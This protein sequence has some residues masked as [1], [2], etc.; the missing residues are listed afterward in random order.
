VLR[1]RR[2]TLQLR[3][4]QKLPVSECDGL[5]WRLEVCQLGRRAPHGGCQCRCSCSHTEL[6]ILHTQAQVWPVLQSLIVHIS[7]YVVLV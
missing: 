4:Y 6:C 5:H 2:A 7:Y 1:V 3:Y